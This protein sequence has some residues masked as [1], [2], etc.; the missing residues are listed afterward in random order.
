MTPETSGRFEA[1]LRV[2]VTARQANSASLPSVRATFYLGGAER[3]VV[4]IPSGSVPI[5]TE[6]DEG[7]LEKSAD[8]EIPGEIVQPGLEM[9]IEVDPEGTLDPALGVTKRI[10]DTG[11]IALDIRSMPLFDLTVIP[12]LWSKAP[13]SSILDLT[14]ALAADP[15][16]HEMRRQ[17]RTLLP[18]GD[19]DVRA[20]E[21]VLSSSNDAFALR[22]ETKAIRALE[23]GGGHYMGM[24]SGSVTGPAGVAFLPGRVSF[25]YPTGE[26]MAHELGHNMSLFHA[27]CGNTAGPDPSFPYMDG[28]IGAWGYDFG[29]GCQWPFKTAHIWPLKSAQFCGAAAEGA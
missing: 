20:H 19:L 10:P 7:A 12:F 22:D 25:S 3:H 8:A 18:V 11:R 16:G 17:T 26:T 24:M 21:P 28:S 14:R 29:T 9:V 27:P 15:D 13:D 6:V 4:N 1:L 2:F 5:P 23:A